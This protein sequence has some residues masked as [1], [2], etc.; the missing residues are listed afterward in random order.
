VDD[1]GVIGRFVVSEEAVGSSSLAKREEKIQKATFQ[2]TG[3]PVDR[4]DRA[5]RDRGLRPTVRDVGRR[6]RVR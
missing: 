3:R 5:R 4:C 6:V 2:N 1:D